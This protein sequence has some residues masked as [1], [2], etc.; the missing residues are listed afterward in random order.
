MLAVAL[1]DGLV[2]MSD[3]ASTSDASATSAP[4][5]A[6]S[7]SSPCRGASRTA[8]IASGTR[9]ALYAARLCVER[10][11]LGIDRR[12]EVACQKA[13]HSI[14]IAPELVY[15]EDGVLIS[16]YVSGRTLAAEDVRDPAFLPRLAAVLRR[17]HGS[18][19]RL[20]G[21]FLYFCT[22]QTVRAYAT[23]AHRL[24]ARL[25]GDVDECLED[26]R[27]L[28]RQL[29]PFVPVL[30]HNDLLASNIIADDGRVWL[31]DWEY[32]GMGHPLFDL[33]CASANCDFSDSQEAAL[34]AGY[35]GSVD[36]SRPAR[37]AHPQ[38]D[39]APPRGALV[40][41]PDDRVGHR[42]RLFPVCRRQ[43][44]GLPAG[45]EET[46]DRAGRGRIPL[47]ERLGIVPSVRRIGRSAGSLGADG[48]DPRE[49]GAVRRRARRGRP[50][51]R[52]RRPPPRRRRP[53]FASR[54]ARA[55]AR[56]CS[57][58]A[59]A[60]RAVSTADSALSTSASARW[61][62]LT[63]ARC[64]RLAAASA[65]L[66]RARSAR[67]A[68]SAA[69]LRRGSS[70]AGVAAGDGRAGDG[71]LGR[72]LLRRRP[73]R[74]AGRLEAAEQ[75]LRRR[76]AGTQDADEQLLDRDVVRRHLGQSGVDLTGRRLPAG[77]AERGLGETHEV[78]A[79]LAQVLQ[80]GPDVGA[81]AAL[82][83]RRLRL[84]NL[85]RGAREAGDDRA[86][87]RRRRR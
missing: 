34:L 82:D 54:S 9:S 66:R 3:H 38:D 53:A 81:V 13:A 61:R 48:A 56:T 25:P 68:R 11:L 70:G 4:G 44:R 5:M 23:T 12:N 27:R 57:A 72:R 50:A 85:R 60:A 1:L 14:G 64:S 87:P 47:I 20:T 31:V 45:E 52:R 2:M 74:A 51:R 58:A 83:G 32:A 21:P 77:A 19:D 86:R 41:H 84:A 63:A 33:A 59:R 17:L 37:I 78:G 62:A 10:P 69:A 75:V 42:F 26:A 7:R 80:R 46:R 55:V 24:G 39:G 8:T 40:R 43:F 18:W 65:S 15:H 30:C 6:R 76:V 16:R 79:A 71:L 29:A 49:R 28:S 73:R 36:A 67:A 22:F 35:R